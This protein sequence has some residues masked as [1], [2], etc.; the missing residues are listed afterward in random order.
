MAE[1]IVLNNIV[2]G[3]LN[4]T[5]LLENSLAIFYEVKHMLIIL[6]NSASALLG[7]I[8]FICNNPKPDI[9]QYTNK[10]AE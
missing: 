5:K 3:V 4:S 2:L 10:K 8:T 9:E 1:S 7:T 6:L